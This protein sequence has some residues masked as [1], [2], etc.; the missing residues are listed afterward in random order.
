MEYDPSTRPPR[1]YVIVRANISRS[2]QA[3]QAGHG[4]AKFVAAFP[5]LWG[6][7]TLIYL[8]VPDETELLNWFTK[9]QAMN[10]NVVCYEDPSWKSQT[11]VAVF[12]SDEI[13]EEL[14]TLSLI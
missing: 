3:I 8:R 1:L 4:V 2:Q 5:H 9:L 11:A 14:K 10:A 7:R 6:N 13:I 12:G